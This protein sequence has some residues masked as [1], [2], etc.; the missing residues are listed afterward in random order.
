MAGSNNTDFEAM[1]ITKY[2]KPDNMQHAMMQRS[3]L[4]GL[5]PKDENAGGKRMELPIVT[6]GNRKRSRTYATAAA[7]TQNTVADAFEVAYRNNF[8]FARWTDDLMM[9]GRQKGEHALMEIMETEMEGAK[10]NLLR[11]LGRGTYLNH[12]GAKARSAATGA[13]STTVCTL[14]RPEDAIHFEKG[15]VIR[16]SDADGSGGA[17]ALRAGSVT[18]ASV[19]YEAGTLTATGNWSAGITTPTNSDYLFH[20]GDF[21]INMYGL[22]AWIPS[23]TTGLGT[24]FNG[25]TRSTNPTRLAGTRMNAAGLLGHEVISRLA[26]RMLRVADA[27]PDVVVVNTETFTDYAVQIENKT[28]HTIQAINGDGKR[29]AKIGYEGLKIAIPGGSVTMLSDPNCP[30][31]RLYM[32][33]AESWKIGSVGKP[34]RIVGENGSTGDGLTLRRGTADDWYVEI[35]SRLNLGCKAPWNNGVALLDVDAG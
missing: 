2:V 7:A 13:F 33:T 9:D 3:P 20:D 11:D 10:N 16:V 1:L 22:D 17:D 12:G 29:L 35:K 25:V 28:Y 27:V 21:G 23:V 19:D 18:L 32:L 14:L 34:F 30:P 8:Q 26:A 15:D 4:F 6:E 24:A 5:L 31:N